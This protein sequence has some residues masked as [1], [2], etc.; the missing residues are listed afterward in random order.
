MHERRYQYFGQDRDDF[1]FSDFRRETDH[2]FARR[3]EYVRHFGLPEP[4]PGSFSIIEFGF[5]RIGIYMDDLRFCAECGW[6]YNSD[7]PYIFDAI[8]QEGRPFH[9]AISAMINTRRNVPEFVFSDCG[10]TR[11][12]AER[13]REQEPPKPSHEEKLAFVRQQLRA[14][15]RKAVYLI[16]AG[17]AYKIGIT[18]N[19]H[20]R[21][22]ALQPACPHRLVLLKTWKPKDARAYER[23]LHARL[24][25]H[26]LQNEW[27]ALP[28]DIVTSLAKMDTTCMTRWL[29]AETRR[30]ACG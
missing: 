27:F 26:R 21:M 2:Y 10:A 3:L 7:T 22:S 13:R 1:T 12:C 23:A 25:D 4:K 20:A 17:Q 19:V 24:G 15:R 5:N 18:S 30:A 6:F 16:Q 28:L 9:A 8:K 14:R 29:D 11:E